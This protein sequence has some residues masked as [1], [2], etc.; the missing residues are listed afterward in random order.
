MTNPENAKRLRR[1]AQIGQFAVGLALLLLSGVFVFFF[2]LTLS[3]PTATAQLLAEEAGATLDAG[4]TGTRY[5]WPAGLSWMAVDLLGLILL[6]TAMQLFAGYRRGEIFAP[7]AAM[8]LRRI[9]LMLVLMAPVS[10][11]GDLLTVLLLTLD[12]APGGKSLSLSIDDGD[13]YAVVIGLIIMAVGQIMTEA[14]RLS[15]ENQSFV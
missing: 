15:E 11:L 2:W 8:R 4:N 1:V 3:D 10:I 5:L 12:N 9:G 6:W 14:L 13:I 7:R